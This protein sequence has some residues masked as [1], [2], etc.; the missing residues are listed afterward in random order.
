[1]NSSQS[2]TQESSSNSQGQLGSPELSCTE[3]AKDDSVAEGVDDV[4]V[5]APHL[6]NA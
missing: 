4:S 5:K 3:V 1:M 6:E 2:E